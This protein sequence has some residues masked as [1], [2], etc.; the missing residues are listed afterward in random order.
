MRDAAPVDHA[1]ATGPGRPSLGERR[2]AALRL[3]IAREAVRLFTSQGVTAT[4]G[5]Q[6]AQ[7]VGIST[8]TLWRHFPTKESCV[9]P[10]LTAG[11][12]AATDE[13]LRRWPPDSALLDF[14]TATCRHGGLPSADPAV[15]DLIRM[16]HTEPALR[17]VWLQAHD[18][19]LS[20]LAELLARRSGRSPGDLRV[21]VH[22]ATVNGALRA[23]AEDFA[24]R[25][26]DDAD[27]S[28]DELAACVHAALRAASEGLPY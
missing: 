23:A 25:F 3:D 18:D 20:V 4:T 1:T 16:T 14:L 19:A 28:D 22:A 9:R 21:R 8:R 24:L 6:I 5:D 26:S 13:L 2:R 7:A 10:L 11:L 27:A 12:D 15:L 17:A